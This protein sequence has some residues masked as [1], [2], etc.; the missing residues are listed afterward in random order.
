MPV[1]LCFQKSLNALSRRSFVCLAISYLRLACIVIF[2]TSVSAPPFL[3]LTVLVGD[4][5]SAVFHVLFCPFHLFFF[6]IIHFILLIVWLFFPFK[7]F[8]YLTWTF[9]SVSPPWLG[10]NS[11]PLQFGSAPATG[12]RPGKCLC[13]FHLMW[14]SWW[15]VLSITCLAS[16]RRFLHKHCLN[17]IYKNIYLYLEEY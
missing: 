11:G 6:S 3:R 17:V 16:G 9:H 14:I 4:T 1:S 10:L 5:D 2:V 8:I 12:P 13:P 15:V 7:I